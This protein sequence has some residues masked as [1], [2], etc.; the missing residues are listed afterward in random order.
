MKIKITDKVSLRAEALRLAIKS[1]MLEMSENNLIKR[2][3]AFEMYIQGDVELPEF[4]PMPDNHINMHICNGCG[5]EYD[6]EDDG[7]GLN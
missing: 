6:D 1:D 3:K 5:E 4:M 2:A 7:I